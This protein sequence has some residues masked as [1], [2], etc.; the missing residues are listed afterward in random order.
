[1]RFP[2]KDDEL[3][4]LMKQGRMELIE[5]SAGSVLN[6]KIEERSFD[7]WNVSSCPRYKGLYEFVNVLWIEWRGDV[8]YRK[9]LGRVKKSAWRRLN[10]DKINVTLG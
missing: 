10:K 1:L 4:T 5:I 2:C 8:A 9:A 3:A 6:Q 7:E